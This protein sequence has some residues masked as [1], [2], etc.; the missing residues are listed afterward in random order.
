ME[1]RK[2][3]PTEQHS[4]T[5]IAL[6]CPKTN[7]AVGW[8][9]CVAKVTVCNVFVFMQICGNKF[10]KSFLSLETSYSQTLRVPD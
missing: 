4:F 2:P 9:Q 7:T 3:L 5:E 6:L 1:Y 10:Y 8:G